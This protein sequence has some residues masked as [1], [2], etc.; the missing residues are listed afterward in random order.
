MDVL[1]YLL[2]GRKRRK[3]IFTL[4]VASLLCFVL[5]TYF[6]FLGRNCYDYKTGSIFCEGKA[7]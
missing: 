3:E 4:N 1:E 2:G 5:F 7:K 6:F